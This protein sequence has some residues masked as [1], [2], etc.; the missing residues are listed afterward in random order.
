MH[1]QLAFL[2]P[3]PCRVELW[4]DASAWFAWIERSASS[5]SDTA[6]ASEC[7]I[8]YRKELP[9]S[10]VPAGRGQDLPMG[11]GHHDDDFVN[12]LIPRGVR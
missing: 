6:S 2:P 12:D 11:I 5:L 9:W 4:R 7:F 1:K 8:T 3:E 10:I